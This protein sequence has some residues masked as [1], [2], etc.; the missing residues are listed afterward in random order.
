MNVRIATAE[1]AAVIRDL[2]LAMLQEVAAPLPAELP[3][4]IDAYLHRSLA[5]G[6]CLCALLEEAGR[7]V[8]PAM[9]CLGQSVP[10]EFNRTGRYAILASVYTLPEFRGQGRM[11]HLLRYLFEQGRQAVVREILATAEEKALPLY[12]RL[13]FTLQTNGILLEL[14]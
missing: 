6:S 5:N 11:E 4:A 10:D 13:G 14:D 9:L 8:S 3:A 2:R 7:P 12:K 1:D